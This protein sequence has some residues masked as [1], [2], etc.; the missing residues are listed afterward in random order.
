MLAANTELMDEIMARFKEDLPAIIWGADPMIYTPY[1]AITQPSLKSIS[2]TVSHYFDIPAHAIKGTV[3]TKQLVRIRHLFCLLASELT[4]KPQTVIGRFLNRDHTTIG[5]A[6][7]G[8]RD[9]IKTDAD[10]L[11]SYE[12]LRRKVFER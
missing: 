12:I 7:K 9:K 3:R 5:Y 4:D 11:Q 6:I 1:K 8:A 10:Y 2:E